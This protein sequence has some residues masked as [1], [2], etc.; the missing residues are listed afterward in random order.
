MLTGKVRAIVAK[1]HCS[2]GH[3]LKIKA[4]SSRR[5]GLGGPMT[6]KTY[7]HCL[8]LGTNCCQGAHLGYSLKNELDQTLKIVF[9]TPAGLR[10][11]ETDSVYE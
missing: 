3:D 8:P 2:K 4:V 5:L 7:Q 9:R 11:K 6:N 1:L 10:T